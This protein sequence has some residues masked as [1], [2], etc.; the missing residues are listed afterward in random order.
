MGA[1]TSPSEMTPLRRIWAYPWDF[2]D[3]ASSLESLGDLGIDSVSI[4]AAY[5]SARAWAPRNPLRKVVDAHFAAAYFEFSRELYAG[6]RLQPAPPTWTER[7][8]F[9][10]AAER[11]SSAGVGVSAWVV[12]LHNSRLG[13]L[14]PDLTIKNAFGDRYLHALC[15]AQPEVIEYAATLVAD[16]VGGHEF[17]TI[18][19]EAAGYL[20]SAHASH[21]EKNALG[22]GAYETYLASLCWCERCLMAMASA[23]LDPESAR[24]K[25]AYVLSD[26]LVGES[27]VR[28]PSAPSLG[29]LLG[30]AGERALLDARRRVNT[31]FLAAVLDGIQTKPVDVVV[32]GEP[33]PYRTGPGIALDM[34]SISERV[35][36]LLVPLLD[37]PPKE[38]EQRVEA[39]VKD[40]GSLGVIAGVSALALDADERIKFPG[41]IRKYIDSGA[42]GIQYYHFG[43]CTELGLGAIRNTQAVT[44]QDIGLEGRS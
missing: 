9:S 12:L 23:G 40:S 20:G 14:A 4:A 30:D 44:H 33:D 16:L 17:D 32:T 6:R 29:E 22:F 15:P 26:W 38:A 37:V 1:P 43:L 25:I 19:L 13:R 27:S 11:V 39:A 41:R 28:R 34:E 36:Y 3:D 21:H 18:E 2:L 31:S 42:V 24:A 10:R 8:A 35:N 5:H 7:D